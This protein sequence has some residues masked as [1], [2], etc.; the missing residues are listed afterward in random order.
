M[1]QPIIK[2]DIEDRVKDTG[3]IMTGNLRITNS[4]YP[5]IAFK[6]T[7]GTYTWLEGNQAGSSLLTQLAEGDNGYRALRLNNTNNSITSA[8]QIIDKTESGDFTYYT[9][10]HS[11]NKPKTNDITYLG[12][13]L[14][15]ASTDT[16]D[17]W[18]SLGSGHAIIDALGILA[19]QPYQ[20][21]WLENKVYAGWIIQELH[22][23][24]QASIWR[25]YGLVGRNDNK[26]EGT[27][28]WKEMLDSANYNKY[29]LPLTGG[30]MTGKLIINNT[31]DVVV[32]TANSG[33]LLIGPPT[34]AHIAIDGN[35]I[36]AKNNGTTAGTLFLNNEG[37]LVQIGG[38][39]LK[40]SGKIT[41][42]WW[43]TSATCYMRHAVEKGTAP[44]S[45]SWKE[46]IWK[47]ASGTANSDNLGIV[48]NAYFADG[49]AETFLRVYTPLSGSD[50]N[51]SIYI[52]ANA[53]NTFKAGVVNCALYGAV[54]NDYAEF[55]EYNDSTEPPYGRVVIE[56]GDDTLSLSTKRL[57]C[58]GNICSDT[59]GFAIG[60][61]DQCK[62]PIAVSG[63]ALVYTYEDRNTYQPGE[64]LCTG[65]N[66]T[67]SRMTREE[68]KEYPDCII[69][70]VSAIP[71]YER[72]GTGNVE[73]NGRIWI[74]VV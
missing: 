40:V 42:N 10:Y 66:G 29:A 55:R 43:E 26:F 69:G 62:M 41:A 60:E 67:V 63:R 49:H 68:I 33:V 17:F 36:M 37:G 61:T 20:W 56:N 31:N 35:E 1:T 3:D 5:K 59:F 65:P 34:G 2:K 27:P 13:N 73:V 53:D 72:W 46:L 24:N 71:T 9:V 21:C 64:A 7:A 48:G 8:L 70:Y 6:P 52:S 47:D 58:G 30:T 25:R 39:G 22:G 50:N 74:K 57:Q 12:R 54:W 18:Q 11:G 19:E 14:T 16:V 23:A 51:A 44:A 32:G 28:M 4:T 45:T 38:G 15:T